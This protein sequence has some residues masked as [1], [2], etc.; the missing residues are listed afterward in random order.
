MTKFK[1]AIDRA[2]K[3]KE[4]NPDQINLNNE[5]DAQIEYEDNYDPTNFLLT[6]HEICEGNK[7]F[8]LDENSEIDCGKIIQTQNQDPIM[9]LDGT[10][11]VKLRKG[12]LVIRKSIHKKMVG[13]E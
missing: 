4:E 10:N 1:I 8:K 11:S 6:Q 13:F 12:N 3:E 2:D 5:Q 7:R 9:E